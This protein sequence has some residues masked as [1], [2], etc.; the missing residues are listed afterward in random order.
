MEK[1]RPIFVLIIGLSVVGIVSPV[2]RTIPATAET[3]ELYPV[4]VPQ[5]P[6]IDG[7]LGDDIWQQEPLARD[8]SSYSPIYGEKIPYKTLV[9]MAYNSKNLYFAFKCYDPQPQKIKTSITRRDSM[10]RDDWVGLSLDARGNMHTSY[11]LFVNPSGIQGDALYS[12]V[13]G[14][15]RGRILSG[16]VLG[17][18]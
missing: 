4:L 9:W 2:L 17:K 3:Q 5:G 16:K 12:S 10:Y 1:I 13:Q 8:F 6:K 18:W 7:K 15:D 11:H 14:E